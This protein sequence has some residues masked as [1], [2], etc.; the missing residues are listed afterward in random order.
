M[1]KKSKF[2]EN[3]KLPGPRRLNK[4]LSGWTEEQP[5]WNIYVKLPKANNNFKIFDS[6]EK[7]R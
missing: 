7:K 1:A 3:Y 4:P 5:H 6:T 2:E